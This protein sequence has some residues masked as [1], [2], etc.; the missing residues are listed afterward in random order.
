MVL[1][2][3]QIIHLKVQVL[4]HQIVLQMVLGREHQTI[5]QKLLVLQYFQNL[6]VQVRVKHQMKTR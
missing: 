4:G 2:Y 6:L 5:L 1:E 3:F